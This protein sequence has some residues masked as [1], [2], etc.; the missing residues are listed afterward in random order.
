MRAGVGLLLDDKWVDKAAVTFEG[1]RGCWWGQ[2]HH[3]TFCGLNA[4]G[5]QYR[6]K[7]P[8]TT[9]STVQRLASM[10]PTKMLWATDNIMAMSYFSEFLPQV[11]AL[12]LQSNGRPIEFLRDQAQPQSRAAQGPGRCQRQ[13]SAAGDR[14]SL[15]THLLRVMDKG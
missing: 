11:A 9:L 6:V 1:S 3:C 4:E 2:K 13:V 15:S 8:E 5:M 12:G 10:Y 14:E 7:R